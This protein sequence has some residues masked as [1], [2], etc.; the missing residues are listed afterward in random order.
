MEYS[1]HLQKIWK[2]KRIH[3][4]TLSLHISNQR[5]RIRVHTHVTKSIPL[6]LGN[7]YVDL[8]KIEI[9]NQRANR[10]YEERT[11]FQQRIVVIIGARTE[12]HKWRIFFYHYQL[13][14]GLG[15]KWYSYT[16]FRNVDEKKWCVY[17]SSDAIALKKMTQM[18]T[19]WI[20]E[21]R[22]RMCVF[23]SDV[24]I[25]YVY[26]LPIGNACFGCIFFFLQQTFSSRRSRPDRWFK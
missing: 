5:I 20:Y 4:R 21:Q 16:F 1:L 17:S 10:W 7:R 8:K 26:D 13:Y 11:R 14:G 22:M 6:I 12:E 23:I 3:I 9:W 19:F 2:N 24:L 25:V 15:R 18:I